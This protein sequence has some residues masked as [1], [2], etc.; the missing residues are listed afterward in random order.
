MRTQRQ[1]QCG[2]FEGVPMDV[3]AML[4]GAGI[5]AGVGIIAK[6]VGFWRDSGVT[7]AQLGERLA[8]MKE[9]MRKTAETL[10]KSTS[11]TNDGVKQTVAELRAVVITV[12]SLQASQDVTNR[13]NE[14]L[15]DSLT[16][17]SEN[18][19]RIINETQGM[20]GQ[21]LTELKRNGK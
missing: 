8:Q 19:D 15:F 2:D 11:E 7:E 18:H 5:S 13:V 1:R 4:T 6:A 21:V 17:K 16:R 3:M 14:K 20:I 9:E 12:A 10:G